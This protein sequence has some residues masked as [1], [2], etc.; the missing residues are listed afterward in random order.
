MS[1]FELVVGS[2]QLTAARGTEKLT[3]YYQRAPRALT[4]SSVYLGVQTAHGL[5]PGALRPDLVLRHRSATGD[6][7]FLIEAK[8]GHRGVE[9]SSRAALLDI[10]AYRTAFEARMQAA[11]PYGLGI[12][13]GADLEPH[14]T[15][16]VLLCSPEASKLV[17]A[18][19]AL[20]GPR[21]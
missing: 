3:L 10:L 15:S 12:A 17:T 8:G 6:R 11:P 1:R 16:P 13:W 5:A 21:I 20:L 14:P 7:W 19:D 4:A 9:A 18:L 2:L